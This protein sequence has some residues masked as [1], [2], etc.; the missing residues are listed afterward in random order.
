[1]REVT[2][3]AI[4]AAIDEHDRDPDAFKRHGFGPARTYMLVY[5][6]REYDSK[7]IV[8]VAHGYLPGREAL[9]PA[10]FSGGEDTV[11]TLLRDLGFD[12]RT[13]R[14]P[15]WLEAE[16]VL[17]CSLVAKNNW[18]G[19][20]A[21]DQR[22]IALSQLLQQLPVHPPESRGAVF[23]NPNSV[24]R[25]TFDIATQHPDYQGKPTRGGKLDREVL[26]AFLD[27]PDEM[28]A[29]AAAIRTGIAAGELD[30]LPAAADI[31]EEEA[32]AEGRV[33]VLRHLR[34]ERDPKLRGKKINKVL[35]ERGCLECEVCGFDF[36]HTYGA[37][38]TRFAEVHH[39]TPL[40]VTG[41]TETRLADLA[42][43]CANC[44]RMI[45]RGRCWLTP[46]ELRV[47]VEQHRGSLDDLSR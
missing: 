18:Q 26:Q 38:G 42:V 32:A 27:R 14:S 31:D 40:H 7:A 29:Q 20:R 25:K 5:D 34:R 45:H 47:V 15:A 19:I 36:E 33:L 16:L 39:L 10:E 2:R 17:A 35:A 8:G 11:V 21:H 41:A 23:R 6:T 22:A 3:E 37:R 24:Q 13:G 28:H 9:S 46:N 44:H 12:I 4:L 30:E 43:L 1:M